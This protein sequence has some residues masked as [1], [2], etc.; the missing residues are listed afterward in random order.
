M[1]PINPFMIGA[2]LAGLPLLIALFILRA[3]LAKLFEPVVNIFFPSRRIKN[4]ASKKV[5]D[6][7]KDKLAASQSISS[8]RPIAPVNSLSGSAFRHDIYRIAELESQIRTKP[9]TK[10][11]SSK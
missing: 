3:R 9:D 11:E 2:I 6:K 8:G 4:K 5:K 1:A 10:A 7:T